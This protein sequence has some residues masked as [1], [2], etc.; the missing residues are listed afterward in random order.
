M[1]A[2]ILTDM[3]PSLF[4]ATL[5]SSVSSGLVV[6]IQF[7]GFIVTGI[8][9]YVIYRMYKNILKAISDVNKNVTDNKNK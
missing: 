5:P 4:A 3:T 6:L 7:S 2:G 1:N 8:I 9:V